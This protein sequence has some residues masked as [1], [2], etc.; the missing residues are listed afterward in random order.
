MSSVLILELDYQSW[1]VKRFLSN[2]F[3]QTAEASLASS[4]L[5]ASLGFKDA[6]MVQKVTTLLSPS[7]AE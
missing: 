6:K 5:G 7:G 2:S 3:V 4:L 1:S